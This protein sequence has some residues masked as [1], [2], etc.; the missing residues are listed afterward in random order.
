MTDRYDISREGPPTCCACGVGVT[1]EHE[2]CCVCL[3]PLHPHCL[4]EVGAALEACPAD[5]VE[6]IER[7]QRTIRAQQVKINELRDAI[8]RLNRIAVIRAGEREPAPAMA[9]Y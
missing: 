8:D 4:T 3:K 5:E 7:A 9:V 1:E 2:E 6:A